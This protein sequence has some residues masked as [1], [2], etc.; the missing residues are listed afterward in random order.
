MYIQLVEEWTSI[1][2]MKN[3]SGPSKSEKQNYHIIFQ[4]LFIIGKMKLM[5]CVYVYCGIIHTE[6]IME[7]T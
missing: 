1:G 2:I 7:S 4:D 3:Q 5:E 6:Q